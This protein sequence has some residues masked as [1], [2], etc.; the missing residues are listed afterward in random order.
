MQISQLNN[1]QKHGV[2]EK[3][4]TNIIQEVMSQKIK[5]IQFPPL[6]NPQEQRDHIKFLKT[7]LVEQLEDQ[8]K[9]LDKEKQDLICEKMQFEEEKNT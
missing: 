8:Q 4:K 1:S 2:E 9:Q 5:K 3:L 6:E 7:N